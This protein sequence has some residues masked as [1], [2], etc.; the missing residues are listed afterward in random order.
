MNNIQISI[1]RKKKNNNKYVQIY[2]LG[3][4]ITGICKNKNIRIFMEMY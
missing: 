4:S 3:V 1:L 2:K